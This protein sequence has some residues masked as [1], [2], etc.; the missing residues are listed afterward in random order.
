M[1][2]LT[3]MEFDAGF[4]A[5]LHLSN[6]LPHAKP[7]DDWHGRPGVTDRFASQL[8]ALEQMGEV[9]K[10]SGGLF[11]LGDLYDKRLIDAVTL[12][13]S[14]TVLA[15]MPC[16]VYILPGNHDAHN[17]RGERFMV[18]LF[19]EAGLEHVKVLGHEALEYWGWLRF[20]P[21]PFGS[22]EGNRE[23]IKKHAK[24]LPKGN[25]GFNCLLLHQ[26]IMG[27]K[28][29]T[30]KCDIG[31]DPTRDIDS[32]FNLVLAGHFHTNQSLE[33]RGEYVGAP[34]QLHF[35]ESGN[36]TQF[37]MWKFRPNGAAPT[38]IKLP[39]SAFWTVNNLAL[40][41]GAKPGDF[42]KVELEA[43]EADWVK[44]LPKTKSV[45]KKWVGD[46]YRASCIHRYIP[47]KQTRAAT[48]KKATFQELVTK[49]VDEISESTGGFDL[50]RLK[51]LG[52]KALENAKREA[53]K[54]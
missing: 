41:K 23:A 9:C 34:L 3:N 40:P 6:M 1:G 13:E 16:Q 54:H 49:Y 39:G 37:T 11:I 25:K 31:L 24:K 2:K 43:T 8:C 4:T 51:A 36:P 22:I 20:C 21:V 38:R 32:A 53:E 27:A 44:M 45:I 5:D 29:G 19:S 52:L 33:G 17:D 7:L 12:R 47:Q 26:S 50:E 48:P 18:E 10:D 15:K 14:L 35:G 42:I 28:Q 46:G 30:W